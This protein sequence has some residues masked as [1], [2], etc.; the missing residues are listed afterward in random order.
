MLGNPYKTRQHGFRSF[1]NQNAAITNMSPRQPQNKKY[2]NITLK[3]EIHRQIVLQ[4]DHRQCF[5][6]SVHAQRN[7]NT[8]VE[9][10]QLHCWTSYKQYIIR[11][12]SQT[13]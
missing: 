7:I 4:F 9:Q 1:E 11:L 3:K 5:Q 8:S 2:I 13:F 6:M 12:L 10:G